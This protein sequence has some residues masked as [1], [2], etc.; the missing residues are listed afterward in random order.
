MVRESRFRAVFSLCLFVVCPVAGRADANPLGAAGEPAVAA[1]IPR[2]PGSDRFSQ[3]IA[4]ERIAQA[5][6]PTDGPAPL[7]AQACGCH[8]AEIYPKKQGGGRAQRSESAL[9]RARSLCLER[10]MSSKTNFFP[11][12]KLQPCNSDRLLVTVE[13]RRP[14][15]FRP[16]AQMEWI[17][18]DRAGGDPGSRADAR[19][20]DPT[21]THAPPP[22]PTSR[23]G[24][25][26]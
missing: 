14:S 22:G 11:P 20:T 19:L 2:P 6:A 26:G 18:A 10:Y 5:S 15:F 16:M 8:A 13:A 24:A 25:A 7:V 17:A 12:V 23:T 4:L 3:G 9:P 1:A 21:H